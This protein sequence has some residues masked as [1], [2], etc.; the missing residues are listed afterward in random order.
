MF[1]RQGEFT[2][3]EF[4]ILD[5]IT[6][7]GHSIALVIFSGVQYYTG[8]WFPMQAITSAAKAQVSLR[9]YSLFLH[10]HA[11]SLRARFGVKGAIALLSSWC[12][13]SAREKQGL[14]CLL[15]R[16]V[17]VAGT[18]PMQ[19]EMFPWP[20]TT[21]MSI[22]PYGVRTSISIQGLVASADCSCTRNGKPASHPSTHVPF[23]FLG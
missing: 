8:Q 21:G 6:K 1:P 11:P 14:T 10:N 20:C 2:L 3:R 13:L 17:F 15:R 9:T 7:E 23:F 22:S 18:L 5:V 4:D 19:S 16:D 12:S